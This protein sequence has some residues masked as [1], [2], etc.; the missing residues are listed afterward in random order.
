MHNNFFY[1]S[2][3]QSHIRIKSEVGTV[4]PVEALQCVLLFFAD[5]SKAVQFLLI[6]F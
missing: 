5:S 6:I 2:R 4:K 1:S 3:D